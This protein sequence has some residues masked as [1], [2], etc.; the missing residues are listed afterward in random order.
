MKTTQKFLLLFGALLIISVMGLL[1]T[2]SFFSI[3]EDIKL[4]DNKNNAYSLTSEDLELNTA[5][6]DNETE[7]F[8]CSTF[9]EW[10]AFLLD[11]YN[12]TL[13]E[14]SELHNSSIAIL[15][16]EARIYTGWSNGTYTDEEKSQ[17][18]QDL[19][20]T[21][22][23]AFGV[24]PFTDIS[25]PSIGGIFPNLHH[26]TDQYFECI[27]SVQNFIAGEHIFR[28]YA[29]IDYDTSDTD[30]NYPNNL[31]DYFYGFTDGDS[32][33]VF[34]ASI[35][36]WNYLGKYPWDADLNPNEAWM[37]P[38]TTQI[39]KVDKEQFWAA[40]SYTAATLPH[41]IDD[42]INF[43]IQVMWRWDEVVGFGLW[44]PWFKWVTRQA[45]VY[46][47][48]RPGHHGALTPFNIYDD[49]Q[50][51]PILTSLVYDRTIYDSAPHLT[52]SGTAI[53]YSG[54]AIHAN[55]Y[56]EVIQGL[57]IPLTQLFIIWLPT[58]R[59]G[60]HQI[61]LF[62]T[63]LDNDRPND[64]MVSGPY[65]VSYT[66]YDDDLSPPSLSLQHS[67]ATTDEDP[68]YLQFKIYEP[69]SGSQAT[70]TLT[71]EGPND[72]I[73]SNNYG[74]GIYTLDLKAIGVSEPGVYSFT[75]YAE[76]NDEDRGEID[77]ES[78][79]IL[80]SL[81]IIDDD[82]VEPEIFEVLFPD[83]LIKDSDDSFKIRVDA[84]DES[85][86]DWVRAYCNGGGPY[87]G[88]YDFLDGYY[89]ITIPN[90]RIPFLHSIH[91][92]VAD[93]DNDREEDQL[94][95]YISE[96]IGIFDD[97]ITPPTINYIDLPDII[98]DYEHSLS[99]I[100]NVYDASGIYQVKAYLNGQEY[101]LGSNGPFNI[102][103]PK[104]PGEYQLII[105]AWDND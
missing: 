46:R 2:N 72:F 83:T 97:D 52:V 31:L 88:M 14:L 36:W 95:S 82:E 67:G 90:P 64:R 75:L 56:G 42:Q 43:V 84:T 44:K 47:D 101:N 9:D 71:I 81:T 78:R 93:N 17:L 3:D 105:K 96:T 4:I 89:W 57:W 76:N 48:N 23:I 87:Y 68:G 69:N 30:K 18:L 50:L 60:Y 66:V 61:P 91:I 70:A 77:E 16:E 41:R 63:D 13:E 86:I 45:D 24:F 100:I 58:D 8:P 55:Y 15:N 59:I 53:D 35:E 20:N 54:L 104:K 40:E 49:D 7:K 73:Y 62:L 19:H 37:G 103:S 25:L 32:S 80:R 22:R 74:E 10:R 38:D 102:P 34:P 79:E 33:K 26:H 99:G 28:V 92:Q 11:Y 51:P 5:T 39:L 98:Y 27:I 12:T 94:I 29:Y 85:G 6:T 21:P 65:Y 1:G